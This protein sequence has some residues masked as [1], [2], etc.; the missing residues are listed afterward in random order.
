[1]SDRVEPVYNLEV[2]GDHCYRVGES[3]V[4]V[5]NTSANPNL[6]IVTATNST[7]RGE[8]CS[9]P[10]F[11]IL[12]TLASG[13]LQFEV[14]AQL[15]AGN[16]GSVSGKEFFAAMMAHFSANVRIVEGSWSRASGLTTN[17]DQLN[18]ATAA[19]LSVK[20]AAPLTWTGLRASE[21]GYD[22]VTVT[23]ATPPGAQGN[24]DTAR[25]E[26]SR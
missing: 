22:K 1:M 21:Y 13:V 19:G 26:F 3:G 15:T 17:I 6:N 11:Y 12:T 2:E 14:V 18:R 25:V 4:L 24:Y 16:R 9:D 23:L 20:D 7:F 10:R 5:H 8:D